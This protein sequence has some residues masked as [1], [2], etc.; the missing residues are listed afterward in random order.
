MNV[1]LAF[2][3]VPGEV[4]V[5]KLCVAFREIGWRGRAL[6]MF[7]IAQPGADER[8]RKRYLAVYRANLIERWILRVRITLLSSEL[9]RLDRTPLAPVVASRTA[10]DSVRASLLAQL[11]RNTFR[12]VRLE[13]ELG[14]RGVSLMLLGR[15][16]TYKEEL[17]INHSIE[18]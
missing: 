8:M 16:T 3:C 4:K 1:P 10:Y 9:D 18:I 2:D 14:F 6:R 17:R 13:D 15:A 11:Y 7:A 5:A 12:L